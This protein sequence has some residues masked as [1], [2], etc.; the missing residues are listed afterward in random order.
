MTCQWHVR[1]AMTEAHVERARKSPVSCTKLIIFG[2]SVFLCYLY[3]EISAHA[4]KHERLKS[5]QNLCRP[6]RTV[7]NVTD[8]VQ[9]ELRLV[10]DQQHSASIGL[11]SALEL[12]LGVLI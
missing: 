4:A 1:A 5:S 6:F 7:P 12:V 11:Q 9:I 8:N 2:W 10:A 3:K